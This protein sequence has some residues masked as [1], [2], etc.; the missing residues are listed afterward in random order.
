M[1]GKEVKS[2][3]SIVN[4]ESCQDNVN[5]VRRRWFNVMNVKF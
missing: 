2:Q 4:E 3:C 5:S 1:F